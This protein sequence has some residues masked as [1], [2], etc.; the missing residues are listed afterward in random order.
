L[1]LLLLVSGAL[2]AAVARRGIAQRLQEYR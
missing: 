1:S 2:A